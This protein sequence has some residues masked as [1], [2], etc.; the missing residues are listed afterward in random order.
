MAKSIK[1]D[2]TSKGLNNILNELNTTNVKMGETVDD[3]DY[4]DANSII[5]NKVNNIDINSY[6]K[7]QDNNLATAD[8]TIVGAINEL[9]QNASSG[10]QL[11]ADA[12]GSD[13]ID[14]ESTYEAMSQ[15]IE[16]LKAKISV[17][18]SVKQLESNNENLF[19]LK[20]TGEL[21]GLGINSNGEL[22]LEDTNA[23]TELVKLS[24]NVESVFCGDCS[25]FIV[26]N[27]GTAYACGLN[28]YGQLGIGINGGGSLNIEADPYICTSGHVS[29][30]LKYEAQNYGFH[31]EGVYYL[32]FYDYE[33]VQDNGFTVIN[34]NNLA[35]IIHCWAT[36]D[37]NDTIPG[38]VGIYVVSANSY[39]KV[40]I[41]DWD[42]QNPSDFFEGFYMY[43]QFPEIAGWNITSQN[44]EEVQVAAM[45]N[46]QVYNDSFN[47]ITIE[48]EGL[49]C[50][51]VS[52][53][54]PTPVD[55]YMD[56]YTSH[57]VGYWTHLGYRASEEN[58]FSI[59]NN[60]DKPIRVSLR[61]ED[62]DAHTVFQNSFVVAPYSYT[63][64]QHGSHADSTGCRITIDFNGYGLDYDYGWDINDDNYESVQSAALENIEMYSGAFDM[65]SI[66]RNFDG[67]NSGNGVT[68]FTQIPNITDV[69]QISGGPTHTL[70]VKNDGT[71]YACGSNECKQ[72]GITIS[73]KLECTSGETPF[74]LFYG[75]EAIDYDLYDYSNVSY[76]NY[77]YVYINWWFSDD[78][79]NSITIIN[80]NDLPIRGVFGETDDDGYITVST[81]EFIVPANSYY[82]LTNMKSSNQ[83]YIE[84]T[85]LELHLVVEDGWSLNSLVRAGVEKPSDDSYKNLLREAL[86]HVEVYDHEVPVAQKDSTK[87]NEFIQVTDNINNDVA[88]VSC[89]RTHSAILKNDGTIWTCGQLGQSNINSRAGVEKPSEPDDSGDSGDTEY[90]TTFTKIENAK[91][92][93]GIVDLDLFNGYTE[94]DLYY[95]MVD[96]G[97]FMAPNY[98][99]LTVEDSSIFTNDGVYRL[100]NDNE[101]AI[102]FYV[103][104]AM[105][106]AVQNVTRFEGN[107]ETEFTVHATLAPIEGAK[108]FLHLDD[109][110]T[111]IADNWTSLNAINHVT[112]YEVQNNDVALNNITKIS[113]GT[114]HMMALKNDGAIYSC[115]SNTNGQLG[116]GDFNNRND[117]YK[118]NINNVKDIDC[119]GNTSFALL[120]DDTLWSSGKEKTNS[121]SSDLPAP[122]GIYNSYED[123][124]DIGGTFLKIE[125]MTS[126]LLETGLSYSFVNK[127]NHSLAFKVEDMMMNNTTIVVPANDVV[128]DAVGPDVCEGDI[129]V[130][131]Y[132]YV[133]DGWEM[134]QESIQEIMNNTFIYR[135][136]VSKED[137][138]SY[139]NV[140]VES[141]LNNV[142]LMAP[143]LDEIYALNNNDVLFVSSSEGI[144]N[145]GTF[146]SG[147]YQEILCNALIEKG[148]EASRLMSMFELIK[149]IEEEGL[150]DKEVPIKQIACGYRHVMA[151]KENGDLWGAGY[152]GNGQLGLGDFSS[153]DTFHKITSSVAQVACGEAHTVILKTDGSVWSCGN[154]Y[155]NQLGYS[156]SNTSTFTKV[157]TNVSNTKQIACGSEHTVI[158]KTDGS[159]WACGDNYYGQLGVGSTSSTKTIFTQATTNIN[160]DVKE[161]ACGDYHTA[162]LKND[163]SVWCC[164]LND[165]GQL[166]IS[167]YDNAIT[168]TQA[169]TN[170]KQVSCGAYFTMIA[171]NDDSLW[172]TGNNDFCQLGNENIPYSNMF[173][174]IQDNINNDVKK[175]ACGYYFTM[176]I[177]NDNSL[178]ACG[179]TT[180]DFTKMFLTFTQISDNVKDVDCGEY[181]T[182]IIKQDGILYSYGNNGSGQLGIGDKGTTYDF[183]KTVFTE[184]ESSEDGEIDESIFPTAWL[185]NDAKW[186]V[187]PIEGAEYGFVDMGAGGYYESQNKGVHNSAAVCRLYIHNPKK[188]NVT[189]HCTNYAESNY[190]YGIVSK[191]N[192]ELSLTHEEDPASNCTV[193]FKNS[194]S[195]LEQQITLDAESGWYYIKFIKDNSNSNNNDSLTFT[196][197]FGSPYAGQ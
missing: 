134:T 22:G 160:N 167:S 135:G 119:I 110:G 124:I 177:K 156:S 140:F 21:Y 27:D 5:A 74:D 35:I 149:L 151:L 148:F 65:E 133:S 75:E 180:S 91:D 55:K 153:R 121:G 24:D 178:W 147:S 105:G 3:V 1:L 84:C 89:G 77:S 193:S 14:E 171:K 29:E 192:V 60:N 138:F 20:G 31:E 146:K 28:N 117:F 189:L 184:I 168:F 187:S 8:K 9:F 111:V 106:N 100:R 145:L 78:L 15:A 39:L 185:G 86:S 67:S 38:T 104:D 49:P 176:I 76:Y 43:I 152:N 52:I 30:T 66:E 82:N 94:S 58:I 188:E 36:D 139:S 17:Q 25:T 154:N 64:V 179:N 159:V 18:D 88:Q 195:S 23:R 165:D 158:L 114:D 48:G 136:E 81:Y 109:W 57:F 173:I 163:G 72:L 93:G 37:D 2:S 157:T 50:E 61:G 131:V 71:L 183:T 92:L 96:V 34:N 54:N 69:K 197:S 166:G 12:I 196:V 6:Q 26:K 122:I 132:A 144:N 108:I 164:G 191:R 87:S 115:G 129:Y 123:Y 98:V 83:S 68:S 142:K 120:N 13:N 137:I 175:I 141:E 169:T 40:P 44:Y 62:V 127:C 182:H 130:T 32:P 99:R 190:D 19:L 103:V 118:V 10:K 162:I 33:M 73:N 53:N 97:G 172:A 170:A 47:R 80:N 194:N 186:F 90:N 4:Q 42:I 174:Q 125:S 107:T 161:I 102:E 95:D 143:T 11:I 16:E 112:V 113:S 116:L 128:I 181:Y 45:E 7:I 150:G 59:I 79:P 101:N 85:Q 41:T 70:L 56:N 46:I 155:S 63:M 126:D 51:Y